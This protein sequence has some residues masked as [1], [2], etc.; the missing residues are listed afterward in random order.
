[1]S[2]APRPG[3]P[4][5]PGSAGREGSDHRAG[6][7]SSARAGA[8]PGDLC[9]GRASPDSGSGASR[10][11]G[12]AWVE[13]PARACG[14]GT[15]ASGADVKPCRAGPAATAPG[16]DLRAWSPRGRSP[17]AR[18]Y[19]AR[20]LPAAAPWREPRGPP[21]SRP[22]DPTMR[23][24]KG[25]GGGVGGGVGGA[26]GGGAY[27]ERSGAGRMGVATGAPPLSLRPGA[28]PGGTVAPAPPPPAFGPW[29]LGPLRL[30]Q[31]ESCQT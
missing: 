8:G 3:R 25:G 20:V 21:R 2:A 5:G 17:P 18:G 12:A 4:A 7:E 10:G 29:P 6:E 1:M 28:L 11:P 22:P 14:T 31:A 24:G 26:R 9:P 19:G 30:Q 27:V 13:P 16:P 23:R 15:P